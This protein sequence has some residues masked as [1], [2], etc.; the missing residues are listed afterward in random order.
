MERYVEWEFTGAGKVSWGNFLAAEAVAIV[1]D[2][3]QTEVLTLDIAKRAADRLGSGYNAESVLTL[4]AGCRFWR[5][6]KEKEQPPILRSSEVV[7]ALFD[8]TGDASTFA[9]R[10]ARANAGAFGAAW[11]HLTDE[12]R[13]FLIEWAKKYGAEIRSGK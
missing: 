6:E 11:A 1:M 4:T 8:S 2:R 12:K 3:E 5:V 9:E 10:R 13:L 7:Q